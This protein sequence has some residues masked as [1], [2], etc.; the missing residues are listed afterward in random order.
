MHAIEMLAMGAD[1][2]REAEARCLSVNEAHFMAHE[3]GG[4]AVGARTF[5]W[6]D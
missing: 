6:I 1:M 3:C 4:P 5:A 2:R